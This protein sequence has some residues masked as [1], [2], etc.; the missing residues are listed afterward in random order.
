MCSF[1]LHLPCGA[2]RM[3]VCACSVCR[4][5][6]AWRL[7]LLHALSPTSSTLMGSSPAMTLPMFAMAAA[8]G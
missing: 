7:A 1:R 3:A 8:C 4:I 6:G 2:A 5:T